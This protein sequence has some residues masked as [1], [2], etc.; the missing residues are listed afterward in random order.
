MNN[1]NNEVK[2]FQCK[3][4]SPNNRELLFR[5]QRITLLMAQAALCRRA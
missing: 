5:Y 4:Q 1:E 3:K 2:T